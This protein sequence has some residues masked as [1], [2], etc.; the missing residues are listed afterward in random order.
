MP[1]SDS[2]QNARSTKLQ[3]F[4]LGGMDSNTAPLLL[5][6][7]TYQCAFNMVH[8]GGDVTVRPRHKLGLSIPGVNPQCLCLFTPTGADFPIMVV[9]AD[10]YI[11]RSAWPY[12]TLIRLSDEYS[13]P[14]YLDAY[15]PRVISCVAAKSADL[16]SGGTVQLINPQSI[17]YLSDGRSR[18]IRWDG[19]NPPTTVDPQPPYFGVPG[20]CSAMVFSNLRLFVAVGPRIY[21]SD[22]G[23]PDAFTETLI[24]AGGGFLPTEGD[25]TAMIETPDRSG[26]IEFT[27]RSAYFTKSSLKDRLQWQ[28]DP[29]FFRV[30]LNGIG[31]AGPKACVNQF[32]QTWFF[33]PGGLLSLNAAIQTYQNSRILYDDLP[34][35][36]SKANLSANCSNTVLCAHDDYLLCSV[37]SGDAKN[38]HT[39]CFDQNAGNG[40]AWSSIWTGVRPADYASSVIQ[41]ELQTFFLS[42]DYNATGDDAILHVWQ[43]FS[44]EQAEPAG[45]VVANMQTSLFLVGPLE[46]S[47]FVSAELFLVNIEGTLGV[48]VWLGGNAGGH[49]P[50]MDTTVVAERGPY[51]SAWTSA[52][53]S[54]ILDSYRP[55]SRILRT[56]AFSALQAEAYSADAV[57][58][59][60]QEA[61]DAPPL[62]Q[63]RTFSFLVQLTG[64]G[65]V[66]SIRVFQDSKPT[67]SDGKC[68]PAETSDTVQPLLASDYRTEVDYTSL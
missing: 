24:V 2:F 46:N 52:H 28:T 11:Y 7:S 33:S 26:V 40:S 29:E 67:L 47:A 54:D 4:W 65:A 20:A 43:S 64:V 68:A 60:L 44:K 48:K 42:A 55:Q 35:K 50:L 57:P 34:M 39:W 17:L 38:R 36:R 58:S 3:S 51:D 41:G 49:L 63:A 9:V 21:A 10:G 22:I 45:P 53:N 37:P 31:C 16:Q 15:A 66:Q 19:I 18:V 6:P 25:V 61:S 56:P 13:P 30:L 62:G 59:Q 1:L 32:G 14:A 23:N 5:P 12:L 8:R 27:D